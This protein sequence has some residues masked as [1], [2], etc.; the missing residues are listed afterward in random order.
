MTWKLMQSKP[1]VRS[2]NFNAGQQPC[3]GSSSPHFKG[4]KVEWGICQLPV[5]N[6]RHSKW[7]RDINIKHHT[8]CKGWK[9]SLPVYCECVG[10]V[11]CTDSRRKCTHSLSVTV[12][13]A[14]ACVRLGLQSV[15]EG[16]FKPLTGWDLAW[17]KIYAQIRQMKRCYWPR[18][19]SDQPAYVWKRQQRETK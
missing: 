10:R 13:L 16:D 17:Q 7:N 15:L 11:L 19:A 4:L 8:C 14:A 2:I 6:T 12:E 1:P 5:A 9:L 3:S 18:P